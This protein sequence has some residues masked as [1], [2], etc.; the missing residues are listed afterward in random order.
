MA[1]T[2][3]ELER[4]LGLTN[5]INKKD[6]KP[7]RLQAIGQ[8]A[9]QGATWGFGDELKLQDRKKMLA[10]K[11]EYP[12]MSTGVETLASLPMQIY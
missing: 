7:T 12:W 2:L 3:E 10:A 9:L 6:K 5:V 11:E 8:A 4:R 1:E